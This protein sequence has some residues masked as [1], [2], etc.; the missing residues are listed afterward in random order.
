MNSTLDHLSN[1][2]DVVE[3]T[4]RST[5]PT[6]PLSNR[7]I[8]ANLQR[9]PPTL[10]PLYNSCAIAAWTNQPNVPINPTT[11]TSQ[12]LDDDLARLALLEAGVT[13]ASSAIQSLLEREECLSSLDGLSSYLGQA[14]AAASLADSATAALAS[15]TQDTADVAHA[16]SLVQSLRADRERRRVLDALTSVVDAAQ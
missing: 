1:R 4:I 13:R 3:A 15:A 2:L 5:N 9:N 11:A 6:L 7:P 16:L 8:I 12:R 14:A 10:G